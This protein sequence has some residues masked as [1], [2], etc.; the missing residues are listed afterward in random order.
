MIIKNVTKRASK[1]MHLL[2]KASEGMM[3]LMHELKGDDDLKM[4]LDNLQLIDEAQR[5]LVKILVQDNR[6]VSE[7]D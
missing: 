2:S 4:L 1:A 6:V 3:S 7:E 5:E